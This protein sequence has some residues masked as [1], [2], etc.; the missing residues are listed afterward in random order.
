ME[1][2]KYTKNLPKLEK[3]S[4]TYKMVIPKKVEAK[5]RYLQNKFPSTEWSG[6][7]FYTHSGSFE[8]NDL[9]ITCQDIFPMD[10]GNATFTEFKMS[11]DVTAYIAENMDTLWE[12]ETGLV[13]SHHSMQTWFSETDTSTLQSEGADTN[14]FV[15]LIV[16]NAGTYSAAITR[17]MQKSYVVQETSFYQFF[18]TDDNKKE[19]SS[20]N[21]TEEVI[22][23]FML[24]IEVQHPENSLSF[25]DERFEEIKKKKASQLPPV[26]PITVNESPWIPKTPVKENKKL[27]V[28]EGKDLIVKPVKQP[29]LFDEEETLCNINPALVRSATVKMLL[30]S[31]LSNTSKIN[32]EYFITKNM[33]NVYNHFFVSADESKFIEY[34]EWVVD[35]MLTYSKPE[36]AYTELWEISMAYAIRE[37][38]L[39]YENANSYINGF[40]EALTNY[41]ES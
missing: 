41:I 30:C 17:K 25:L 34:V 13:H 2:I 8:T 15:S 9:I 33:E 22:E 37:L 14:N 1:Q 7:L 10:L 24:D 29:T 32:M 38:L 31:L 5:I 12:C 35:Y 28:P 27:V 16:N 4:S 21:Q 23:Y 19:E 11:E 6:I 36:E 20:Y 40:I 18:G 3:Q 26:K 39:K